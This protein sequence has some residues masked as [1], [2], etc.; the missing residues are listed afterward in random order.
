[1][2]DGGEFEI[3]P[4]DIATIAPGHDAWIVGD[5]ACVTIDFGGFAGYVKTLR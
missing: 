2:D 1:M 4:G 5:E 3:G